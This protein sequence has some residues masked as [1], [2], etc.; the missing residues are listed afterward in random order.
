M[1]DNLDIILTE[2]QKLSEQV[3]V[4]S[5][6][7]IERGKR[8]EAN[9]NAIAGEVRAQGKRIVAIEDEQRKSSEWRKTIDYQMQRKDSGFTRAIKG[10]TD[11]DLKLQSDQAAT[12]I[13]LQETQKMVAATSAQVAAISKQNVQSAGALGSMIL[14]LEPSTRKKLVETGLALLFAISTLINTYLM[15]KK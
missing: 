7:G 2:L 11:N 4:V 13:A 8:Q 14:K 1:A 6:E 3:T 5:R 15:S 12:V 9:S 10:A